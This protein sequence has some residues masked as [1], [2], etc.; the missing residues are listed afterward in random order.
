MSE[1]IGSRISLVSKSEIRYIGTLDDINSETHTVALIDVTSYGTEGRRP[2][3]EMA[4]SDH[5]FEYIVFRGS[6]VKDLK[7]VEPPKQKEE[8]DR[9][10]MPDDPAI[11]GSARPGGQ[12]GPP[13]PQGLHR[14]N[15][16]RGPPPGPYPPQQFGGYP[17][18]P[19]P[20][21][22]PNQPPRFQGPGG[23]HG[24]PG[25]PGAV[26][27][28]GMG[29]G[30]PP[31]GYGMGFGPPPPGPGFPGQGPAPGQFGSPAQTPIGLPGQQR[32]P[33]GMQG[34]AQPPIGSGSNKATP[35]PTPAQ[36]AAPPSAPSQQQKPVEMSAVATPGPGATNAPPGPPPPVESKPT[37]SAATAPSA[38]AQAQ[39][40]SVQKAN[41]SRVAVP[42]PSAGVLAAKPPQRPAA[43]Q[44]QASA[45]QPQQNLQD[46][47]QK[48]TAAVAAAMAKLGQPQGQQ[49][50]DGADNLTR[51]MN[52]MRIHDGEHRGRGRGR[53]RG[54]PPREGRGGRRESA[55]RQT[56]EVPKEDYDFEGANAKFNKEDLVKEAIA[57]GEPLTSPANGAK[58]DPL[59]ADANG[60]K[61]GEGEDVVI[62]KAEGSYNKKS[63]FFDNI[64]SDLKDRME[65]DGGVDGRA[66]RQKE[67]SQNMETFGQSNVDGG[68]RGGF[69]GRGRG[70]GFR[71]GRGFESRGRGYGRGRG[72]IEGVQTA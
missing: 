72:G 20:G 47:T 64:S 7:I 38:P 19:P 25:A 63:S 57:S 16:F 17:P 44:Q 37:V 10:T 2:G 36:A 59:S 34:P 3:N 21:Q 43:S 61:D 9:P 24:F 69:R 1:Y 67:R 22:F 58:E 53:G 54:G 35:Q 28:Y 11:L 14:P 62:P 31:P 52:N 45:L 23:P 51:Q 42:L 60:H 49:T 56:V 6:D 46:A 30:P 4:G 71:G 29:Y 41:A 27:G 26:P 15:Q 12:Q 70:R 39:N 48:A 13:P 68:Y 40:K 50:T 18:G 65:R 66:I 33:P 8:S 32:P 55:P 5:V